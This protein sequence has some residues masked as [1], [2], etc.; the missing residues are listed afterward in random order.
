MFELFN[1]LILDMLGGFTKIVSVSLTNPADSSFFFYYTMGLMANDSHKGRYF[2]GL[3]INDFDITGNRGPPGFNPTA[4]E[5][6]IPRPLGR[7]KFSV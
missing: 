4:D 1:P 6:L 3:T 7:L 2:L 5:G